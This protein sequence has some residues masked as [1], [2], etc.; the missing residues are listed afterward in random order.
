MAST[1]PGF[2]S[3]VAQFLGATIRAPNYRIAVARVDP[4]N[5]TRTRSFAQ[6]RRR[7]HWECSEALVH[8]R[9]SG[10]EWPAHHLTTLLRSRDVKVHEVALVA[11]ASLAND[12]RDVAVHPFLNYPFVVS[13]FRDR[14]GDSDHPSAVIVAMRLWFCE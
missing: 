8:A 6:G 9:S 12:N 5:R 1:E 3:S 2:K 10:S 13:C 7:C 4:S 11:L 14:D